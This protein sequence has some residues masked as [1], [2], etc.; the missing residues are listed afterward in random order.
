MGSMPYFVAFLRGLCGRWSLK[1][2]TRPAPPRQDSAFKH[3][4]CT[5]VVMARTFGRR[6][7]GKSGVDKKI[8]VEHKQSTA[9][10]LYITL[11]VACVSHVALTIYYDSHGP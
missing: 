11:L 8:G 1:P 3:N 2:L 4:L 7:G 6:V 5:N 9:N 10:Q